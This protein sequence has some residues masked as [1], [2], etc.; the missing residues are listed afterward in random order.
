MPPC[1][2]ILVRMKY[3]G[4]CRA[5][6]PGHP[7]GGAAVGR[8]VITLC[9]GEDGLRQQLVL[10]HAYHNFCLPHASVRVPG[11]ACPDQRHGLRQA[12]AAADTRDGSRADRSVWTLREVLLFRVPP[13]PQPAMV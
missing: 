7:G 8:R 3:S 4:F 11:R 5:A 13:W 9:K 6:Q 1:F 2:A 10:F 12:V